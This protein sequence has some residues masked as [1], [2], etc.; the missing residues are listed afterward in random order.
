VSFQRP[1]N[2]E[3]PDGWSE[4]PPAN[5]QYWSQIVRGEYLEVPG[6]LLTRSQVQRL[7]GIGSQLCDDILQ[8]LITARFLE[9]TSGDGF[10]RHDCR[11]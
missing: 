2:D 1:V 6:L 11:Q 9:R 4:A 7:W 5:I 3:Q 8:A 10:V